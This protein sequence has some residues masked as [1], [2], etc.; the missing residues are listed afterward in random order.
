LR[1][2][3]AGK[4]VSATQAQASALC[5]AIERYSGEWHGD[6]SHATLCWRDMQSRHGADA[7]HPNA[8]MRYSDA[9]YAQRMVLNA[10]GTRFNRV[11]APLP[12]DVA[13]DWTA[14]WS[15]THERV[16]YLP[17]QLVAFNA[18]AREGDQSVYAI[19]CSNGNA[20]GNTLEEAVLQ[21]FCELVERDAVAL[22]WYNR[23]PRAGV[24]LNSLEANH[25]PA[26]LDEYHRL[27]RECWALD[28]TSD[29]GIPVVAALSRVINRPQESILMGLGCHLDPKIAAQRAFAELNQML[30]MA[31]PDPQGG[32]RS[33]EDEEVRR[34]L[35]HATLASEPYLKPAPHQ[36][37]RRIS[38]LQNI[39][40]GDLLGD[41]SQCR[42][43]VQ[44]QGMEVLALNQTRPDVGMPMV[45][46]IVPGLRHFWARFGPG[47]LYDVP[48]QQGWL[49]R[50]LAEHE[51]NP[52]S[53]FI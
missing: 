44:A 30:W 3:S 26:L 23:L 5:E 29:L 35:D 40:S 53:V 24:D 12:D 46:V 38:E 18:S 16:K 31:A 47:R 1:W 9:Q 36:A 20:A 28:L 33:V 52:T 51:L 15:L 14:V 41:I 11:P 34:W 2:G 6:P 49:A 21:G 17:T 25:M 43:I 22:W 39:S 8:V 48:V 4:G 13:V 50:P 45:K 27:G 7:I 19:G 42:A 37:L 32:A 10:R